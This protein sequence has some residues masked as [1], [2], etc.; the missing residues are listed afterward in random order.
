MVIYARTG[1]RPTPPPLRHI[2]NRGSGFWLSRARRGDAANHG[3]C[4]KAALQSG[5]RRAASRCASTALVSK[6]AKRLA[7]ARVW[8][9]AR[10]VGNPPASLR[11]SALSLWAAVLLALWLSAFRTTYRA[12]FSPLAGHHAARSL[13]KAARLSLRRWALTLAVSLL[14]LQRRQP[15][16]WCLARR[17]LWFTGRRPG[18]RRGADRWPRR[19]G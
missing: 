12:S 11:P 1:D 16:R 17:R 19:S 6:A 15:D 14:G 10:A 4:F 7:L 13:A 9:G 5:I 18:L 8:L 2:E 3:H